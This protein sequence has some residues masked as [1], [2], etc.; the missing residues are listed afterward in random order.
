MTTKTMNRSRHGTLIFL[1]GFS[2]TVCSISAKRWISRVR[3]TDLTL[4]CAELDA[5]KVQAP[6]RLRYLLIATHVPPSASGGGIIRYT[7]E[8]AEAMCRRNDV[9]LHVLVAG[10]RSTYFDVL[11]P[12]HQVHR[13]PALPVP[14]RTLFERWLSVRILAQGHY[15]IVH[16]PK[17]V[18]PRRCGG[19]L[20]L[21]TV[22]DMLPLDRPY[23]FNLL[24]RWLLR[25]PYLASVRGSDLIVC[26]SEATEARL[27][28]YVP[29]VRDRVVVIPLAAASALQKAQ[30]QPVAGLESR[31]FALIVSDSSRRKNL[32]AVADTWREVRERVPGAMLVIVGPRDG[33]AGLGAEWARLVADG[34]ALHLGHVSD[35]E[36]R[37][38]YEHAQVVLCPSVLEGFGLP[39]SE[40]ACFGA[41]VVTTEDPALCEASD[42]GA[43]H[44]ASRESRAWIN[45][46]VVAFSASRPDCSSH[47]KRRA[48][49]WDDV[50]TETHGA[51]ITAL[52][53]G[54]HRKERRSYSN[55]GSRIGIDPY[56]CALKILH[57]VPAGV[58]R[59]LRLASQIQASHIG[60]GWYVDVVSDEELP[61]GTVD[62]D[63]IV[64][65][66]VKAARRRHYSTGTSTSILIAGRGEPRSIFEWSHEAQLARRTNAVVV[67]TPNDAERWTR[68]PVPLTFIRLDDS[69]MAADPD[70]LAAI[71]MR[72]GAWGVASRFTK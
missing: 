68:I 53:S 70:E 43:A 8:L 30:P 45:A 31:S 20:R 61:R 24:K 66:G 41:P 65:Y 13:I 1:I 3:S 32:R 59:L 4:T 69:G 56:T 34:A 26:V 62:Y 40:A 38:C 48:R 28:D 54:V 55:L 58:P 36:L 51:A 71:L 18:I 16:G 63:G 50:A 6:V 42:E 12:A 27:T 9:E 14:I 29:S 15:H 35:G 22:H 67:T 52:F 64:Y 19:A 7:V 17:H 47:G 44:I 60:R 46:V 25:R 10:S 2:W 39:A 21:L 23:D 37:W 33:A 49:T 57:V 11:L 5:G 72:A